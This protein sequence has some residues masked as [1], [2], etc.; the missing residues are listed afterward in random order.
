MAGLHRRFDLGGI[1]G[2]IFT[3]ICVVGILLAAPEARGAQTL[4][5]DFSIS[6]TAGFNG[7]DAA[8]LSEAKGN[9][10]GMVT[11]ITPDGTFPCPVNFGSTDIHD[12]LNLTC[13]IGPEEMVTLFR[14]AQ[15]AH[16]QGQ[17]HVLRNFLQRTRYLQG[18]PRQLAKTRDVDA[19]CFQEY[20]THIERE[21]AGMRYALALGVMIGA[22]TLVGSAPA[23]AAFAPVTA[24]AATD[25]HGGLQK[26]AYWW[27]GRRYWHRRW[28]PR[29]RFV[30]GVWIAPGW[31]YY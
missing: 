27:H 5:V 11:V 3:S 19:R 24:P 10:S 22:A 6:D 17:R 4:S 14:K 2:E 1:H 16:R 21:G 8:S 29:R 9:L 12:Q 28:Y 7:V 13:T 20:R 26:V 15:P 30:G 18:H 31:G 23:Q 25:G